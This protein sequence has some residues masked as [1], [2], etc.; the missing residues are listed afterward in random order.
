MYFSF[1]KLKELANLDASTSY[2]EVKKAINSIGFEVEQDF[3]P[4]DVEGVKFGK[5]LETSKNPNGDKLTVCKIQ[6]NDKIRTI[7]TAATNVVPGVIVVAFVPGSKAKGITYSEKELKGIVSE[8]MLSSLN[9]FGDLGDVHRSENIDGITLYSESEITS[10]DIDPIKHLGLD[11]KI[12]EIKILSNRSD[13]VSYFTMAKEL[14]AYF[15]TSPL[16]LKPKKDSLKSTIKFN[17]GKEKNIA[18]MDFKK[19]FSIQIKDQMLLAKSGIKSINDAVDF[20][21]LILIMTGQPAHVYNKKDVKE[22]FTVD[23]S[24]IKTQVFGKKDVELNNTITVQNGGKV[25]SIA[26]VIGIEEYSVT[27]DENELVLELGQF[28]I[29]DVRQAIRTTKV[30]NHSMNQSAKETSK[31]RIKLALD[32]ARTFLKTFSDVVGFDESSVSGYTVPFDK[33]KMIMLAGSDIT[34]TDRYS[35]VLDSLDILGIKINKNDVSVP[36]YRYDIKNQNDI[37]EEVFRFYGYD[38]FV[39][40]APLFTPLKISSIYNVKNSIK[41][42]GYSEIVTYTLISKE[43][44][45]FDPF[46]FK[47]QI[48][49]STFVSKER[50]VIRDSQLKSM[51]EICDYHEKRKVQRISFF[52]IG[53]I[54]N[55]HTSIALS[56]NVKAFDEMKNDIVNFLGD[57]IEFKRS[58]HSLLHP[59]LSAD[60]FMNKKKIGWIATLNPKH[61]KSSFI[62]A[63]FL[64]EE[65]FTKTT[66]KNYSASPLKHIDI[67]FEID[68]RDDIEPK[69]STYNTIEG[70]Y[71]CYVID[72]FIK[73]DKNC[74]TVRIV[75]D[76]EVISKIN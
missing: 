11:D 28:D 50:E 3:S 76:E 18:F 65:G 35:K 48:S 39:A 63:E 62:F 9:E 43:L 23:Y 53:Q 69:I 38:N 26:G 4:F 7:Q 56:S 54:N 24:S 21:N 5:V 12:I 40:S 66:F 8:G 16:V 75:G 60:I 34:K 72:Q 57:N 29:K 64:T 67:T 31:G 70:I 41:S 19:D 32:F 22:H 2:D 71:D 33:E 51:L 6:F 59:N 45:D 13:A 68:L 25:V 1:N 55:G 15:H 44:N 30:N 49:L 52:E 58:K 14:A 37:V 61:N 73:N 10:L 27:H 46:D 20:S 74:V 17:P 47:K 36:Y 42:L